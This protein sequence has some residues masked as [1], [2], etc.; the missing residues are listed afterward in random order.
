ML[1]RDFSNGF[2][3]AEIFSRYFPQDIH[4]HSYDYG[5]R[6]AT[7]RDNWEQLN[8]FFR[9]KGFIAVKDEVDNIIQC[10]SE[11]GAGPLLERMYNF[12]TQKPYVPESAAEQGSLENRDPSQP[13]DYTSRDEGEEEEEDEC[14][15]SDSGTL[16]ETEGETDDGGAC[17]RLQE[18]NYSERAGDGL[19]R[20]SPDGSG[21]D[22]QP[23]VRLD[24]EE[25]GNDDY[26]GCLDS[27]VR[28]LGEDGGQEDERVEEEQP[29]KKKSVN[30]VEKA[31][32]RENTKTRRIE[33]AGVKAGL[34]ASELKQAI[35]GRKSSTDAGLAFRSPNRNRKENFKQ[36]TLPDYRRQKQFGYVQLGSLGPKEDPELASKLHALQRV[37]EFGRHARSCNTMS[38]TNPALASPKAPKKPSSRKVALEFASSIPKPKRKNH[39]KEESKKV[40]PIQNPHG[41]TELQILEMKHQSHKEH[42]EAIRRDLEHFLR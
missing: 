8:K 9:K 14:S 19:I 31:R 5:S 34:K 17:M 20:L 16:S 29:T 6:L 33:K 30:A 42:V 39:S 7:K 26:F 35:A 10:N 27:G 32:Q 41:L 22:F 21:F 23:L 37:K 3:V 40:L 1:C 15:G 25:N 28:F 2:M 36:Y 18:D 12:L 24:V 13:D 11:D 4:M 38:H